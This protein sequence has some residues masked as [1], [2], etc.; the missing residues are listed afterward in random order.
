MNK[1]LSQDESMALIL[2]ILE[3]IK[4]EGELDSKQN[5][6]PLLADLIADKLKNKDIKLH[7]E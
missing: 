7:K 2:Q 3:E 5:W 1:I 4:G 6:L